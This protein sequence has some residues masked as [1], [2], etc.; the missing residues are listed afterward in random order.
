M[1]GADYVMYG[2][3]RERL[4]Y[5]GKREFWDRLDWKPIYCQQCWHKLLKKIK[6]LEKH[7]RRKH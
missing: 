3:C 1:T 6:T 7:D 5:D 2:E 4:C